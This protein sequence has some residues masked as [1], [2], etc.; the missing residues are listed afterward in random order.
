MHLALTYRL[1]QYFGSILFMGLSIFTA[2][3]HRRGT[4]MQM[5]KAEIMAQ[6]QKCV[7]W[8]DGGSWHARD[9]TASPLNPDALGNS[10]MQEN[11]IKTSVASQEVH[12]LY[13]LV[14]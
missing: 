7:H 3:H 10:E 12:E 8:P 4:P 9:A 11:V 13:C 14:G 5:K 2:V 1:L 6:Q